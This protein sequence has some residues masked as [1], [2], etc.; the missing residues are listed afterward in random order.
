MPGRAEGAGTMEMRL[1]NGPGVMDMSQMPQAYPA[2]QD[3][4]IMTGND[5]HSALGQNSFAMSF[6]SQMQT[7]PPTGDPSAILLHTT[8]RD[9]ALNASAI[10]ISTLLTRGMLIFLKYG[11]RHG[12]GD[13][14]GKSLVGSIFTY[15]N[16]PATESAIRS[17]CT[18]TMRVYGLAKHERN[19]RR[20][21]C[22]IRHTRHG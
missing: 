14:A 4:S 18:G 15:W 16:V 1:M 20:A 5:F 17:I 2:S 19:R 3:N 21:S 12:P 8:G 6:E 9:A 13:A 10:P 7:P 11:I 22:C